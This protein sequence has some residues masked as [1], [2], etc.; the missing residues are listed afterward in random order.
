M[1]WHLKKTRVRLELLTNVDMLLK[2]EKAIRGGI[3][4]AIHQYA[5]ANNLYKSTM[6]PKLPIRGFI[7]NYNQNSDI[8]YFF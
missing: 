2:V 4:H 6:S 3:C 8:G 5:E 1:E 7:K